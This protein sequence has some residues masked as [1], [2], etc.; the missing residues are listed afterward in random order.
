MKADFINCR[1]EG[2]VTDIFEGTARDCFFDSTVT[3]NEQRTC[4][5]NC[6]IV[7]ALVI[8]GFDCT[9]KDTM[10]RSTVTINAAI[11][12][13]KISNLVHSGVLTDNGTGTEI[14]K[15]TRKLDET[16]FDSNL[17]EMGGVAQ[18]AID[19]KDL[20]DEGYDPATNKLEGVKLVDTTT[21]NTDMRGT[22]SAALAASFSFTGGNVHSH[23]KVQDDL[24]LTDQQKLDV[25]AQADLALTD[26]DSGSGVA[27]ENS[28]LSIQNNTRFVASV[29]SWVLIPTSAE[30]VYKITAL[31]Y[32]TAGNME[33]PDSVDGAPQ[34]GLDLDLADGSDKNALV[35][36]DFALTT[37]ATVSPTFTGHVKMVKDAVGRFSTFVKIPS[38]ETPDQFK[39]Q[40][41]LQEN[42]VDLFYTR[43]TISV[44]SAP[45]STTLA[46]NATNKDIIA[47][48][49]KERDVS[50]TTAVS[51]SVFKDTNDN[52]DANET[53]IDTV[54]TV[55]DAIKLKT[56]ALPAD[57][58]SETNVDANETKIDAVKGDTAAIKLKTDA[59]PADPASESNVDANE[60]KIDIVDTVVDAIKLKTDALPVDP[61]SETNVDANEAK[62]DIIDTVVDAIKVE[63]DKIPDILLSLAGK[64]YYVNS[65]SG[66]GANKGDFAAPFEKP[67]EAKAVVKAGDWVHIIDSATVIADGVVDWPVFVNIIQESND[68]LV[69]FW[70]PAADAY[71]WK[72]QGGCQIIRIK[73]KNVSSKPDIIYSE[74]GS[75][76]KNSYVE[77][78]C[79]LSRIRMELGFAHSVVFK[80]ASEITTVDWNSALMNHLVTDDTNIQNGIGDFIGVNLNLSGGTFACPGPITFGSLFVDD[81]RIPTDFD[82]T[83]VSG[84]GGNGGTISKSTIEGNLTGGGAGGGGNKGTVEVTETHI[85]GNVDTGRPATD[86]LFMNIGVGCTVKGN[87]TMRGRNVLAADTVDGNVTVSAEA[88]GVTMYGTRIR[89]TI[90]VTAGATNTFYDW[91]VHNG[92]TDAEASSKAGPNVYDWDDPPMGE[93]W[94]DTERKQ[95]RHRLDLDGVQTVPTSGG[96]GKLTDLL[97]DTAFL[98]KLWKNKREFVKTAGEFFLVFYDDDDTTPILSSKVEKFGTGPIG[99]LLGTTTPSIREKSTV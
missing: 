23:T 97:V 50:T 51:G 91:V 98:K 55:V 96:T 83:G 36:D 26:Y 2:A 53:K 76:G 69:N 75:L 4:L 5:D 33:D 54:D 58:A 52:I 1:F 22:D 12:G 99:E 88:T 86:D 19:L 70:T 6:K 43:T 34:I 71:L 20:A 16:V 74:T 35:F 29:P 65:T 31:L 82:L 46:D 92:L 21:A 84:S 44:D 57:P 13:T 40:F 32:D 72:F 56:D 81:V 49:M 17:V 45:G 61:A 79:A 90:T 10:T 48:A 67:S 7:G 25:N 89:G 93:D 9:I 30:N 37:P 66:S 63:T 59:L 15:F 47:E 62:L 87:V 39:F 95:I 60:A 28:V 68:D 27:K 78:T 8:N 77:D 73:A 85:H 94:T 64:H 80:G 14:D 42:S 24:A 18:S 41:R 3:L 11:T 38:T